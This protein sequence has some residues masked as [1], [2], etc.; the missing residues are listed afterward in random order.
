MDDHQDIF[1]VLNRSLPLGEKLAYLHTV[2][3]QRFAFVDRIAVA[4]Y[5]PRTETLNSYLDSSP[6]DRRKAHYH[7]RLSDEPELRDILAQGRPRIVTNLGIFGSTAAAHNRRRDDQGFGASYIL[8]MYTNGNFFGFVFFNSY[9]SEGFTAEGLYYL[10][11][12]GHLISLIV[13]NE[14]SAIHT[15]LAAVKTARD[16]THHR[17]IETG[18]HLDRMALYAQLIARVLAGRFGFDDEYIEHVFLFAPL[19]DIGK[20]GV[21]DRILLKPGR[22]SAEEYEE[23]KHHALRG[24]EI[25]DDMLRNFGLDS[26]QRIDVLRN[27]AQYHH[28]A[29]NGSGYPY[30]LEGD[31]IP[32]EARIV[33]V[34]DVFD[35]L[36]SE[37]P[38]KHAWSNDD[39][40][41]AMR[42]LAGVTLDADCVAALEGSRNE[43]ERIQARFAENPYG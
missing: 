41:N 29:V 22:L 16:V 33:A 2:L 43:I 12:F 23:M 40:F 31:A 37:R 11:L 24:R 1:S 34:A 26:L 21:P 19:H 35:A 15:L 27:I 4:V 17:D 14:V 6:E 10:D 5:E 36:T 3:R 32:I 20:I 28:E 39:A 9:G 30:G 8:P 7:I 18:A 13:I 38:Y 42:Q 25:I